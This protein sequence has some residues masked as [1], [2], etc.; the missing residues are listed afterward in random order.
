MVIRHLRCGMLGVRAL[1]LPVLH[2]QTNDRRV[3]DDRTC[4]TK[5]NRRRR[6]PKYGRRT[7]IHVDLGMPQSTSGI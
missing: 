7:T 6:R 4:E 3:M 2:A 1:A 5:G